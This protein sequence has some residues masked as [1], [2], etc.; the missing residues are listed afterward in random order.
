[1]DL[2]GCHGS[3]CELFPDR[4]KVHSTLESD[5][6]PVACKSLKLIF[7][8]INEP[9]G[10]TQAHGD[11]L[12]KLNAMFLQDINDA[13]GFNAQRVVPLSRPG[14]DS[15]KN[16]LI[17]PEANSLPKTT[18]GT[19]VSLLFSVRLRLFSMGENNLG[20]RRRQSFFTPRFLTL[21]Q[22]LHQRPKFRQR[23]RCFSSQH[24]A[25][26]SMEVVRW[27]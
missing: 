27:K 20:V 15:I 5:R 18:L 8:P 6:N 4:G 7:E 17:L 19:P 26:S 24:G 13:G 16:E 10:T 3:K 1:M 14:M 23:I 12:N 25:S 21:S 22:Q 11:E 2:G 9:P